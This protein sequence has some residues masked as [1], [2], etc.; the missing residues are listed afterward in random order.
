MPGLDQ[1]EVTF[2]I[3]VNGIIN[4]SAVDKYTGRSQKITVVPS[5]G[6]SKDQIT[7]MAH[8]AEQYAREAKRRKENAEEQDAV[9]DICSLAEKTSIELSDRLTLRQKDM[10]V[11]LVAKVRSA[12]ETDHMDTVKSSR[13][14][15]EQVFHEIS[16]DIYNQLFSSEISHSTNPNT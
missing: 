16:E 10:L 15:L 13:E 3:D 2:D 14:E 7:M 5:S 12:L 8:D 6:L 4:V 11:S 1:I 9:E